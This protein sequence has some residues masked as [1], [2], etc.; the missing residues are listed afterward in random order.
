MERDKISKAIQIFETDIGNITGTKNDKRGTFR[1][2]QDDAPSTKNFQ[3]DCIDESTNT[4]IYLGL[5]EQL[6]Y[7][8][9]HKPVFAANRQPF[10]SG[11]R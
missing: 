3:Q 6:G 5:L 9:L 10:K 4:T 1:L 7:L 2:Y 11:G 8:E